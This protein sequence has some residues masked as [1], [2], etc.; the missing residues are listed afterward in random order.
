MYLQQYL[1]QVRANCPTLT[2]ADLHRF[3]QG[4]RVQ[5]LAPKENF[6]NVGDIPHSVGYIMQGLFKAVYT[7]SDGNRVNV[8]FFREGNSVCDYQA[9]REQTPSRYDFA[10]IEHSTLILVPRDHLEACTAEMPQLERYYR[11]ALERALFAYVRRT[12]RF[13]ITDAAAR[14]REFITQEPELFKRLSVSDL[15]SYLGI[16][17]Q[18]LTRIRK[19]MLKNA[20]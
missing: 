1:A 12:E 18:T 3:A 19:Q 9:F 13:L 16:Q 14:Y 4:L 8:N 20:V 15:C 5:T 11:I 10:A 7:D 6:L 2:D 17:R